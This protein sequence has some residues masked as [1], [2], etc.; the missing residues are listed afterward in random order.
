MTELESF[1]D[2]SKVLK[3]SIDIAVGKAVVLNSVLPS[4][5]SKTL[6]NTL[7]TIQKLYPVTA[8]DFIIG[9]IIL[10]NPV[11]KPLYID[12]G[13]GE[14]ILKITAEFSEPENKSTNKKWYQF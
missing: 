6:L 8:R 4:E 10:E 3:E 11:G 2:K 14:Q 1:Y 12:F 7:E 5:M 9:Q 13:G